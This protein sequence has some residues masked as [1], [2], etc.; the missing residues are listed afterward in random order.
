M[1]SV[2]LSLTTF[3]LSNEPRRRDLLWARCDFYDTVGQTH[4]LRRVSVTRNPNA[5]AVT[6]QAVSPNWQVLPLLGGIHD[7]TGTILLAR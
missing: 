7:L 6:Q 5:V 4:E 3:L 1:D 2:M